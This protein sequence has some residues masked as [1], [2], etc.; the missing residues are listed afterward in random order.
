MTPVIDVF[1]VLLVFID[2]GISGVAVDRFCQNDIGHFTLGRQF[3]IKF[4]IFGTVKDEKML[5]PGAG[6]H[7]DAQILCQL[8]S[9]AGDAGPGQQGRDALSEGRQR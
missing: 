2:G 8:Q 9:H 3:N 7:G 6:E 1:S 4:N 5:A